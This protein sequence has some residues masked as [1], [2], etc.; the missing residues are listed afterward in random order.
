MYLPY[1]VYYMTEVKDEHHVWMRFVQSYPGQVVKTL[2]EAESMFHSIRAK[3]VALGLDLWVPFADEEEWVLVKWLIARVGQM[4]INEFLKLPITH[5]MKTSFTSKYT[6]MKAVDQL[7]HGTKWKLKRITVEGNVVSNGGQCESEELELWLQDPVDCIHELMGNLE[8]ED[9]VVYAPERMWT[10]DWWWE[11]Q[12]RLQEGAVVAPVILASDKTV[13]SQFRG[14]QE[15]WPVYLTLGNIS[16]DIHRQPSKHAAILIAYLPITKLECFFDAGRD[17]VEITCPDRQVRRMH[18]I[19][20]AYVANFP[21]QCLVACCMENCCPK[22]TVEQDKRGD[23]RLS[24]PHKRDMT[25]EYLQLHSKGKLMIYSPFWVILPHNDIFQCMTPDILHQLHKGVFKDHIISWCTEIIG[26]DALDAH[27]KAM[28]LQRVFLGVI[29]GAVENRVIA[30]VRAVLDFVYYA[31]YQSHTEHTLS[32]MEAALTLFHTN[33]E[34]FVELGVCDHF[35]I[36]KVHSMVHY[37]DSIRLFGSTDGFNTELLERL[38]IDFA[39]RAYRASN[40]CDYVIQ[41]TTWLQRQESLHI[42]DAYLQCNSKCFFK[43]HASPVVAS[44]DPRK[45]PAPARFD[46]ALFI[47][48]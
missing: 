29:A 13:L 23:M 14:D 6:L 45:P 25:I 35:N 19:V 15:V 37:T 27:F 41:M 12:G 21:E 24:A 33:K 31:Q 28:E 46:S 16:K 5:H 3:Q 40:Q 48:D 20:A 8:F 11:M 42:Q 38:H 1:H 39:K 18:P 26:K 44:K 30:A 10:G 17:G 4:V 47:D 43:V 34:V 36:P 2:G 9:V 32:R 7:P 22:C